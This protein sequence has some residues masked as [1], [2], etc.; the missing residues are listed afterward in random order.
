MEQ[1]HRNVR[2]LGERALTGPL[3]RKDVDT[4]KK[5][6]EALSGDSYMNIYRAFAEAHLKGVEL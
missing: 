1:I 6:L 2:L 5:N 3:V 4:L